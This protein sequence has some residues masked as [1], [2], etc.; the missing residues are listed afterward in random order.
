[1]PELGAALRPLLGALR[2]LVFVPVC[3][4]CRAVQSRAGTPP[5]VC[6]LCWSRCQSPAHP[7]CER[8]G[9]TL[10]P[11]TRPGRSC[12]HCRELPAPLRVLRSA[13]LHEG[14]AREM[15]HALKFGGWQPLAEPMGRRLAAVHLPEDVRAEVRTV[16]PVPLAPVRLRERGYNQAALLAA[17]LCRETG[18][19]CDEELLVRKRSTARQSGLQSRERRS[20]VATAFSV[21]PEAR[22]RLSGEHVLLVDDVWTTGATALACLAALVEGGA[23]VVSVLTFARASNP[24]ERAGDPI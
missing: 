23:R 15:V 19:R 2:D 22:S 12:R 7:L 5:L 13:Y 4:S 10:A 9:S 14:P 17:S 6:A 21:P 20:N 11:G 16:V 24:R 18:L 1:M 8:C 3:L